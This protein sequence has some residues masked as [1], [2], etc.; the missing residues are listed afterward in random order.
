MSLNSRLAEVILGH[1]QGMVMRMDGW[2]R[3]EPRRR[4]AP[5]QVQRAIQ[6]LTE[7]TCSTCPVTMLAD[8]CG[9]SRSHFAQAF[10]AATGLPPHKWLLSHRIRLACELMEQTDHCLAEIAQ[11]CGFADQSHFSRRFRAAMG[12]SPAVWR[13]ERRAGVT[14]AELGLCINSR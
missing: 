3:N 13:R 2:V 9:L 11:T 7:A 14:P 5:W 1:R 8:A 4:L 12:N 6:L 10:R